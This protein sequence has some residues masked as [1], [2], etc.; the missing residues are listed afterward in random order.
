MR[1]YIHKITKHGEEFK[2]D[3]YD[4]TKSIEGAWFWTTPES[5]ERAQHFFSHEGGITIRP[6]FG[7]SAACTDFR[8]EPRP[9]GGFAVSCEHPLANDEPAT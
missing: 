7:P 9:Q 5:A 1:L 3:I 6:P 4:F 8:V 2:P